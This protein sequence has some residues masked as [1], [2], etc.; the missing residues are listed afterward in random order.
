M[1]ASTPTI[2]DVHASLMTLINS[3]S[4]LNAR[5][6]NM[7]KKLD[8]LEEIHKTVT[9]LKRDVSNIQAKQND[10]DQEARAGVVRITGLTVNESEINQHGYEKAIM[11]KVYD[12]LLKPILNAAKAS[13]DLESVPVLLNVLEQ[14]Y[15]A[16]KPFV[17]RQ[18]RT[19]PPV[20]NVRFCNR[21]V[22]NTVMRMKREHIPTPS[23]AEVAAGIARFAITED[24]TPANAK[25][26]REV[27]EN[28]KVARAWSVDGKVRYTLKADPNIVKRFPSSF[29]PIS[30]IIA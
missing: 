18:G 28:E 19:L 6:E 10:L 8:G 22:R 15:F 4:F 3:V 14:G 29:T 25:K 13:G 24:L 12:K 1:M 27:R 7:E 23:A 21:F 9:T 17:D 26:L 16:G 11:K 30:D 5:L 20:I 2:S